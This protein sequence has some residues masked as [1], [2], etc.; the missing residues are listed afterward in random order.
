[1]KRKLIVFLTMLML[2]CCV[3]AGTAFSAVASE[4]VPTNVLGKNKA[5]WTA[6]SQDN[7]SIENDI[8]SVKK[9]ASLKTP[10][11]T[12]YIKI[13]FNTTANADTIDNQWRD[14]VM[15]ISDETDLDPINEFSNRGTGKLN[16]NSL[17]IT[18]GAR[19]NQWNVCIGG[20]VLEL[21]GN[22]EHA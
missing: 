14:F 21:P 19:D 20:N 12:D 2:V 9:Y 5:E 1:M 3:I 10:L 8:I 16:R 18:V 4:T 11:N 15:V 7:V 6:S 13:V 17:I 22:A